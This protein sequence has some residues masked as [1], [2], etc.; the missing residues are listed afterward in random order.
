MYAC[1]CVCGVRDH[2][3]SDGLRNNFECNYILIIWQYYGRRQNTRAIFRL[4]SDVPRVSSVTCAFSKLNDINISSGLSAW[5]VYTPPE[6][7]LKCQLKIWNY[8][9]TYHTMC[10]C[11]LSIRRRRRRRFDAKQEIC[12]WIYDFRLA[13]ISIV[14]CCGSGGRWPMVARALLAPSNFYDHFSYTLYSI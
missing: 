7:L 14:T 4:G 2:I 6:C 11:A 8:K 9:S 1:V 5:I 10:V 12:R 13:S 3:N